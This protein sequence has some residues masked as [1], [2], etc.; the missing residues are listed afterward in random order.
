MRPAFFDA[1]RS[2]RRALQVN[3]SV[4]QAFGNP[5]H[6]ESAAWI[7]SGHGSDRH[8]PRWGLPLELALSRRVSAAL[9][10]EGPRGDGAYEYQERDDLCPAR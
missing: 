10:E 9:G 8:S 6:N 7:P 3:A 5:V 2:L 4:G 1:G